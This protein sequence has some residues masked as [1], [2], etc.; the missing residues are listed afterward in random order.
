MVIPQAW[1]VDGNNE[2]YYRLNQFFRYRD[3]DSRAHP[4]P[5]K[6]FQHNSV[7]DICRCH[8]G[9]GTNILCTAGVCTF[10]MQPAT[11]NAV[12]AINLT[13]NSTNVEIN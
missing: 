9:A 11:E 1:K 2:A 5:P 6:L 12:M 3:P 7:A 10:R 4:T 8:G 13:V